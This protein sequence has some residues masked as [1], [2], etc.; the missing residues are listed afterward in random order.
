MECGIPSLATHRSFRCL[1]GP[2]L[3]AL[4][5][6]VG[7]RWEGLQGLALS[8][9]HSCPQAAAPLTSTGSCGESPS[10]SRPLWGTCSYSFL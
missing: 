1:L 2:L 5:G 4:L 7:Q 10:R 3:R 8:V 9:F 6:E